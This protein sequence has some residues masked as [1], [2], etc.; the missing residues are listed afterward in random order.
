[1]LHE[2]LMC[3]LGNTGGLFQYKLENNKHKIKL[4]ENLEFIH[5]AEVEVCN[6]LAE[7]G[8]F[9]RQLCEF[10][11]NYSFG[12][13]FENKKLK[14]GYYLY[15]FCNGLNL[16]VLEPYR[17]KVSELET[18]LL[19]DHHHNVTY[20]QSHLEFH[21]TLFSTLSSLVDDIIAKNLHGCQIADLIYKKTISGDSLIKETFNKI[22]TIT[23]EVLYKQL[24]E[25][26]IYGNLNDKFNEFFIYL[27]PT[28]P[29]ETMVDK[30]RKNQEYDDDMNINE[31]E[32]LLMGSRFSSKYSQFSIESTQLPSYIS[33][34]IA[35]KILFT[36][37]LL[38]LFKAK[39]LNEIYSNDKENTQF[40]FNL[41]VNKVQLIM[42]TNK[43]LNQEFN[44]MNQKMD[45]FSKKIWAISQCEFSIISFDSLIS[46][47]RDYVSE[48]VWSLIVGKYN[49]FGEFQKL[50]DM[51]LMGRGEL[52]ATFLDTA[53]PLLNKPLDQNFEYNI[54]YF[55][56]KSISRMLLDDELWLSKFRIICLDPINSKK[57][58][59]ESNG[60]NRIGLSYKVEWPFHSLIT[61]KVIKKRVQIEL[62][63]CFRLQMRMGTKTNK[64]NPR[65]WLTR[66]HMSFLIDNLQ[67]YLQADVLETQFD[68]LENKIRTSKDFE[69][70][71]YA[72]DTFL[73]KIHAQSFISNNLVWSCLNEIL[74]SCLNFCAIIIGFDEN[75]D[76][77]NSKI[78]PIIN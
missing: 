9:Y 27:D 36:G 60:W 26:L 74:E 42:E 6:K 41:S 37:E 39:S 33:F 76:F 8:N 23:H 43:A 73:T 20:L 31:T 44:I 12:K 29:E 54:N 45:V 53:K 28:Q 49:L 46:E 58:D 52:F 56:Q 15:A 78:E 16:V 66:N 24:R 11:D 5:P 59:K 69:Q 67:F 17:V 14:C 30:T 21:Y 34:K 25:W 61:Q 71:R 32:E 13:S 70:I 63:Q 75:K 22:L 4:V 77:P 7:L 50:K 65:V 2:L 18:D 40:S 35:N 57:I 68:E 48:E 55:F 51:F 62:N 72:H 19:K 64:I 10:Y 1:M 3:L 47:I 38:Q